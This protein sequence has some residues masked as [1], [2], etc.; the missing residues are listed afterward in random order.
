MNRKVM[1]AVL[2]A[3]V[4]VLSA[5]S[6]LAQE[7]VAPEVNISKDK[8]RING[9]VYLSHVV[10]PKQT[11]WSICK[12]YNVSASEL[13]EANPSLDLA[14]SGLKEGQILMIPFGKKRN[15]AEDQ[16]STAPEQPEDTAS[17]PNSGVDVIPAAAD[18]VAAFVCDMPERISLALVLPLSNALG[19]ID[20]NVDFYSGVLMACRDLGNQGIK[21][22]LSVCNT[23]EHEG[24]GAAAAMNSADVAIG[25]IAAKDAAAAS[26]N[27]RP[28]KAMISPLDPKVAGMTDS[29]RIVQAPSTWEAQTR[30]M[31]KWCAE[32]IQP[33]DTVLVVSE[34]D[35]A[36]SA[37]S[38]FL[39][40]ELD[41][42][43]VRY[44]RISY[45]ILK[46]LSMASTFETRA[47]RKGTTRF[48]AASDNEAFVGDVIRQAN[49]LVYK[50]R[51]ATVYCPSKVRSFDLID[52]ESF[53]NVD[54]RLCST[55]FIDYTDADTKAFIMAYRALFGA[56]PNSYAFQG[57]D[58]AKYFVSACATYGRNWLDKLDE[59][60]GRGLQTDFRFEKSSAPGRINTAVRRVIYNKDF[61]ITLCD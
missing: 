5:G 2:A 1:K 43:G 33:G 26:M 40:K 3:T 61:S 12:A 16:V 31:V 17:C 29:L 42:Q 52:V 21:V 53:H 54:L 27:M 46:G 57:Y 14:I 59:F 13:Y 58:T 23:A 39:L 45:G 9:K 41:R 19:V 50:D 30:E 60:P 47:S 36:L 38:K 18:T 55:Y 51:P 32:E 7:Y 56:E 34:S 6:G 15:A 44:A 8:V 35:V 20:G 49:L 25:P 22:D 4:L 37:E 48:F 11:L 28:G 10:V 24:L